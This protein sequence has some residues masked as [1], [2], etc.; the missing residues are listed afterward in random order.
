MAKRRKVPVSERALVQR[1]NRKLKEKNEK[2]L[3]SRSNG[4]GL[5]RGEYYLLDTD[6]HALVHESV[7]LEGM[8]REL[9]VL[10][11]WEALA[12]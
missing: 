1:V 10:K 3:K 7:D 5:T 8:G 11:D 4:G 6:H 9:G 2:V 12:E